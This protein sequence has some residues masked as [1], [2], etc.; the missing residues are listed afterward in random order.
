[1]RK[2]HGNFTLW[3]GLFLL[4]NNMQAVKLSPE[5]NQLGCIADEPNAIYHANPAVSSSKLKV[6]A[7]SA[8]LYYRKFIAK[9]FVEEFTEDQIKRFAVGTAAHALILEGRDVYSQTVAIRPQGIDRRTTVGKAAY[10]AFEASAA[11]KTIIDDESACIV[12]RMAASVAAHPAASALMAGCL[13]ELTW[14]RS[15]GAMTV[16]CRTDL[17]GS[18]IVDVP[19]LSEPV[20]LR[21][22]DLK[23]CESVSEGDFGSFHKQFESLGYYK[24]AGFYLALLHSMVPKEMVPMDGIPFFFVAVEKREP[25][26]TI[27][28]QPDQEALAEGY[29][30]AMADLKALRDCMAANYWPGTPTTVQPISLP[31]WFVKQSQ[32]KRMSARSAIEGGVS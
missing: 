9:T 25:F 18:N 15:M 10:A 2:I 32:A 12:E 26:Q 29:E 31:S 14:R 19:G 6:F 7:K 3:Q 13:P 5:I 27:V 17:F 20:G 24:Q 8:Q 1:M 28:V 23:T 11:G 16:Q 22:V 30:S 21:V 4:F